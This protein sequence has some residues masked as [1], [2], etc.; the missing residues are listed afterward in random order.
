MLSRFPFYHPPGGQKIPEPLLLIFIFSTHNTLR[1]H[2]WATRGVL[3]PHLTIIL[4]G[5]YTVQT[6]IL[7]DQLSVAFL[8]LQRLVQ[9]VMY[10]GPIVLLSQ[11]A[12]LRN[13]WDQ[14]NSVILE[15]FDDSDE[16][17]LFSS[18]IGE[19]HRYTN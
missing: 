17:E 15:M 10:D 6:R 9:G 3:N 2:F 11:N 18:L 14:Q 16:N 12:P 5:E 19:I 13:Q 7:K 4:D 8:I 1:V